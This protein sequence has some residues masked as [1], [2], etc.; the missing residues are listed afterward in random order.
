MTTFDLCFVGSGV[1]S[2]EVI[3]NLIK[4]ISLQ[5]NTIKKKTFNILL[6]DRHKENIG[7]GIPYTKE[8]C[9]YGYFNNPCRLSPKKFIKWS[10]IKKN[11]ERIFDY[12]ENKS[13]YWNDDFFAVKMALSNMIEDYNPNSKKAFNFKKIKIFKDKE[14]EVFAK[15]LLSK[16]IKK[17]EENKKIIH[18][19]AKN[20]DS[21]RISILDSIL[22][23]LAITE[24]SEFKSIPYKVSINEYIEISKI[25]STKKS[26]EFIN[27]I[28]D[29]FLKKKILI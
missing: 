19:L 29:A 9:K 24:I 20:W 15:T 13:I 27:G 5:K 1:G 4:S 22:M 12:L 26:Y 17:R 11:M 10:L 14:D 28:L 18:E 8:F 23:Q 2:S 25:Y 6:I 16:T 7:G 3:F 21:D